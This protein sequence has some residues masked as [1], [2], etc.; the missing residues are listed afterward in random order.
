MGG[1]FCRHRPRI[2][3]DSVLGGAARRRRTSDAQAGW[4]PWLDHALVILLI[5]AL[6]SAAAA[7]MTFPSFSDIGKTLSASAGVLS[8]VAGLA[9]SNGT[10]ARLGADSALFS[11]NPRA[12]RR[13]RA[14]DQP[15][16]KVGVVR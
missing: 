15:D 1:R 7:L 3:P 12:E 5:A 4:R 13:G 16:E 2:G 6:L 11:G 10:P 14:F 9:R 8:V